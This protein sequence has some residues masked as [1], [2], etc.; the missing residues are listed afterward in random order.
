M[1]SVL[2]PEKTP[3]RLLLEFLLPPLLQP[4]GRSLLCLD[5]PHPFLFLTLSPPLL[6]ALLEEQTAESASLIQL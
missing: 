4:G 5:P 3:H 1:T 2:V 6:P